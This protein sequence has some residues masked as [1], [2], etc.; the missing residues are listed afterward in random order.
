MKSLGFI[1][2]TAVVALALNTLPEDP[3]LAGIPLGADADAVLAAM[4][5]GG[6]EV[7]ESSDVLVVGVRGD[8]RLEYRFSGGAPTFA[9][10]TLERAAS[11][12]PAD[13]LE[14]WERRIE[15][16]WGAPAAVS[17]EGSKLWLIPDLYSIALHAEGTELV[18]T[19]RWL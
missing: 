19:V 13:G 17:V 1:V 2:L 14:G 8:E 7:R 11:T 12:L 6:Y 16:V 18:V 4:N 10:Y 5:D 3:F 15:G 9:R